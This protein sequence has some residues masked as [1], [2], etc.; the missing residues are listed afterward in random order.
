MACRSLSEER[1]EVIEALRGE[2]TDTRRT[3]RLQKQLTRI[4]QAECT[5]NVTGQDASSAARFGNGASEGID[6]GTVHGGG[7]L[8]GLWDERSA[9]TLH[10]SG[11]RNAS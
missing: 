6:M 11:G 4:G 2:S 7:L 10:D 8:I 1:F 3:T 5:A 9:G